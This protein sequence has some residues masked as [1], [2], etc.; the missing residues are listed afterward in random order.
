MK[1]FYEEAIM[2]I[3]FFENE[4]VITTS[5]TGLDEAEDELWF[6]LIWNN[7]FISKKSVNC[8]TQ[9]ADFF[10][11]TALRYLPKALAIVLTY[12]EVYFL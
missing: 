7:T 11:N 4:D 10:I 2:E 9:W 8:L 1:N 3:I 6:G 5:D 12:P